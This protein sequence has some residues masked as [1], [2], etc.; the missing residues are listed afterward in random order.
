MTNTAIALRALALLMLLALV[1]TLLPACGGSDTPVSTPAPT[2]SPRVASAEDMTQVQQV[3]EDGMVPIGA[4][5]LIEGE[6]P[7]VMESSSSMFKPES[8]V[9]TVSDGQLSVRLDMRSD[10][11]SYLYPGTALEA[12]SAPESD[13]IEPIARDDGGNS[14]VLPISALDAEVSCAAF[15]R[16]KE[17]WYDRTL[18]FRADSLPLAAFIEGLYPSPESLALADGSYSVEVSLSGGSGRASVKSPALLEVQDGAATAQIVWSSSNYDYMIVDGQQLLPLSVEGGSRFVI[19][20]AVFD[21]AI[22]VLADTT[23]MSEAH[24]IAYTLRFSSVSIRPAP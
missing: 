5:S 14:F 12:A 13:C 1:L 11:Y 22:A 17:L 4:A 20:V 6:Y 21:R 24:E 18:L 7:V 23:A 15:S 3:L 8:C 9:L 2:E 10:S 19:P 16:K